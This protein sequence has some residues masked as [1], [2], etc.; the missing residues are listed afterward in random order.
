MKVEYAI[1]AP[2][3]T[4]RIDKK[5][6]IPKNILNGSGFLLFTIFSIATNYSIIPLIVK[7]SA[8]V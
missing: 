2:T 5:I 8:K 4:I 7:L 6:K 1:H 3:V